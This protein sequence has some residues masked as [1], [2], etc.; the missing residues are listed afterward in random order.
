MSLLNDF[1]RTCVLMERSRKPDGEGGYITTWQEGAEFMDY[2]A[3][4]TSMEA[5]R[6]EQEGVTSVY[7]VLVRRDVPI[8]YGDFFRDKETGITYRVT[9]NPDEKQAP[10][11]AG[12][13]IKKLKYFTAERR[14]LPDAE[15]TD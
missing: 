2:R 4:D 13:T 9:S 3:L 5:R 12:P 7:S 8:E 1:A 11:S 6:A 10:A 15:S 14:A